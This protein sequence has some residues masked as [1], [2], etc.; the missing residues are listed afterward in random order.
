MFFFLQA[1]EITTTYYV[2]EL[3]LSKLYMR[4]VYNIFKE[5]YKSSTTFSIREDTSQDVYYFVEH[6]VV[7]TE[8]P[9]IQHSFHMKAVYN[10]QILITQP[11]SV[12]AW[13]GNTHVIFV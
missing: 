1:E 9:W 5:T 11:S 12:S 4:R 13:P 3:Q 10:H 8:F 6:R 2:Y 7:Q